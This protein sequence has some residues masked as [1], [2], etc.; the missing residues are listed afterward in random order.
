MEGQGLGQ[1]LKMGILGQFFGGGQQ[2]Q[3][4]QQQQPNGQN[5]E[6]GQS[7]WAN[8]A[9]ALNSMRLEP[10]AN[11]ATAMRENIAS[12][13]KQAGRVKTAEILRGMTSEEY[14]NGRVD[15][16]EMVLTGAI[17]PGDA[18]TIAYKK[19][20][21]SAFAEKQQWLK[22]NP[23]ASDE[24]KALAG[25]SM[26]TESAFAE[27]QQWLID[28]PEATVQQLQLAGINPTT[29]SVFAEKMAWLAANPE[30]TAEEKSLAGISV[31]AL[32]AFAEKMQWLIDNPEA[33]TEQKQLA[34]I[35]SGDLSAFAEKMKWMKDNPNATDAM[36][37]AANVMSPPSAFMEKMTWLANN[38]DA[39]PDQRAVVG[40]AN[41][42]AS[43][44]EKL[45]WLKD[46]PDA[47]DGELQVLGISNP[48]QY[49]QQ[50]ANLE[51]M[52]DAG[53]ITLAEFAD[54]KYKLVTGLTP[55]DGKTDKYRFLEMVA[56]D[57]GL[58]KG[59]KEWQEF[60][61]TNI[62]G[63]QINIDLGGGNDLADLYAKTYVP[64]L[65]KETMTIKKDLE[66]AL[67]Q[68]T[69]LGDLMNI[70]EQDT[71]GDITPFTGIFQPLLTQAAR[72]VTSLGLDTRFSKEIDAVKA[73][74]ND[75]KA[76]DILY[77]KLVKTEITKVMT[78]SDVFPMISSLGIGARGLDT[79][80]ERD[81]LISV[82]TGL[83]TMTIDTLKIMTKFRL[84]MYLEGIEKYNRKV[85]SGYFKMHNNNEN[86]VPF[87]KIDTTN[88]YRYDAQG[89]EIQQ[90]VTYTQDEINLI[91]K[92]NIQ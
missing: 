81:F 18:L 74:P 70:L 44:M 28:N 87:E 59:T 4:Q 45:E 22:D 33:T 83:P 14:P 60:F 19:T 9:I 39:T 13:K 61:A 72:I 24:M 43:F 89:V 21:V 50:L 48:L 5:Q 58:V 54:G 90:G 12:G 92:Y 49:K 40:I 68:V 3:Q 20:P 84:K 51:K 16:A 63:Q 76:K 17:P 15:L 64:E 27:K 29:E 77:E 82:M 88:M 69:K 36:K 2:Q 75:R 79:P 67:T 35:T 91:M 34:G 8:L 71:K 57:N 11:L 55:D 62:G 1:I 85:D 73:N 23:N 52:R 86:F 37:I 56:K 32:S 47:T 10:D 78:G 80:A 38:P 46:N 26:P 41:T 53:E 25:I 31:P 42:K 65:V 30:A 7:Q 66:T 6:M